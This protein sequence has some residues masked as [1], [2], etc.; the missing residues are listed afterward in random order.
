M[1]GR[2]PRSPGPARI[3]PASGASA[4]G[5]CR[6]EHSRAGIGRANGPGPE[7]SARPTRRPRRHGR[8]TAVDRRKEFS[9]GG[10]GRDG[11]SGRGGPRVRDHPSAGR[12]RPRVEITRQ[13]GHHPEQGTP[14]RPWVARYTAPATRSRA[15]PWPAWR[16]REARRRA[17]RSSGMRSSPTAAWASTSAARASRRRTRRGAAPGAERGPKHADA[18]LDRRREHHRHVLRHAE[19]HADANGGH[20]QFRRPRQSDDDPARFGPAEGH[21]P[22]ADRRGDAARVRR[23]D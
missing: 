21:G 4:I 3:G 9:P 1:P 5:A 12:S 8:S 15:T 2:S 20:D 19:Q 22:D 7:S 10:G 13:R 6:V 17:W 23:G 14:T 18:Q 16:S 11:P